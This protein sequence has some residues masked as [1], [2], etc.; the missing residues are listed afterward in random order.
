MRFL[1]M[2]MAALMTLAGC[3]TSAVLTPAVPPLESEKYAAIVVDANSDRV[4]YEH[5]SRDARYPA[6][7]TKMMTLYLLF[8]ALDS[9]LIDL[10][11]QIPF[12]NYAASRPPSKLGLKAGQSLDVQAAILALC[13]KSANDVATAVA[14]HL[15]GSEEQF[16]GMMTAKGRLIGMH[17]TTFR[18]ASGLPNSEQ[19]STARDMAML[20]RALRKRFPHRYH[21]FANRSFAYGG[22]TIRGH[23]K[24]LG[25][26]DGVDGL[27]TGYIRASGFNVATS[28]ARGGRGVI[29][30]VMGGES[31]TERDAHMEKLIDIYLPRAVVAGR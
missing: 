15:A 9:G 5:A 18:N 17:S 30:I 16:A 1:A 13:V 20:A 23:N 26:V 12:S 27:K 21:Y 22:K 3:S 11:D 24:L 6:S 8:E 7:L 31:A 19:I 10:S 25:R 14:E 29:A 4:L 28:A 2:I